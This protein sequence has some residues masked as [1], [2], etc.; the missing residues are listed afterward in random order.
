LAA[1]IAIGVV[2]DA[3]VRAVGQQERLFVGMLLILIFAEALGEDGE[4]GVKEKREGGVEGGV[5]G[6]KEGKASFLP[7]RSR[8]RGCWVA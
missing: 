7:F 6:G 3:G 5:E 1:G 8:E 2:G 4:K